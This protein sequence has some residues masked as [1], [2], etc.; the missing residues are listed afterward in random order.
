[1]SVTVFAEIESIETE[2][3]AAPA[4]A[5][6][7]PRAPGEER[8]AEHA[9]GAPSRP[10]SGMVGSRGPGR[11]AVAVREGDAPASREGEA[12][13]FLGPDDVVPIEYAAVPGTTTNMPGAHAYPDVASPMTG[14]RAIV[15]GKLLAPH[16]G[17]FELKVSSNT[18]G[19]LQVGRVRL[20]LSEV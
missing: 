15:K 1:M 2:N 5:P 17:S 3:G 6:A 12:G 7:T 9:E 10:R 4:A 13:T 11:T 18:A 16:A 19:T 20:S 14:T 8:H